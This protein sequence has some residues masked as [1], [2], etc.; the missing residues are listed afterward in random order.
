MPEFKQINIDLLDPNP[1][2][3]RQNLDDDEGL[4]TSIKDSPLKVRNPPLVRPNKTRF[5]IASGHRRVNAAKKAGEKTIWCKVVELSDTDMKREVLVENA[6]R[7]DLTTDELFNGFEQYR[8]ALGLETD[9]YSELHRQTGIAH[10]WIERIYDAKNIQ[11]KLNISVRKDV[12]ESES[13]ISVSMISETQGLQEKDRIALVEKAVDKGWEYRNVREV[14]AAVKDAP[15]K[16]RVKLIGSDMDAQSTVKIAQAIKPLD[17]SVSIKVLDLNKNTTTEQRVKV[18]ESIKPLT[19]DAQIKVLESK[20]SA[21]VMAE[22]SKLKTP[23]TIESV[24][25]QIHVRRINDDEAIKLINRVAFNVQ[26]Q[27]TTVLN[28]YDETI[29][30]I[31]NTLTKVK[32]WGINQYGILGSKGWTEA[33]NKFT[34][35][36]QHMKWLKRKGWEDN[37]KV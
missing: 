23:E 16:V 34:E 24:A 32:S 31:N 7:K 1:W 26:P 6:H 21:P 2:Q 30:E 22:L 18:A 4:V 28:E 20:L 12:E 11:S 3:I 25:N 29:N 10:T 9:F 36:E 33:E 19:K 5:Q 27:V 17:E 8:K 14:K 37:L 15:E 35:I 13:K